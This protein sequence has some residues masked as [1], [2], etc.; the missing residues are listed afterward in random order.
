MTNKNL[1]TAAIIFGGGFLV[2][3]AVKPSMGG[4]ISSNNGKKSFDSK[5]GVPLPN[6]DD[7]E[8]VFLAYTEALN[9][10]EP[11]SKLTELNKECMNEFGMRCYVDTKKGKVIVCDVKGETVLEK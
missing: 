4:S 11:A 10:G 1:I 5:P 9:N 6:K 2:F 3:W 8:I 7:A